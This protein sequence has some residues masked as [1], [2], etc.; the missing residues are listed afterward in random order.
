MN[1]LKSIFISGYSLI[2]MV[3]TTL[4]VIQ[5]VN[6]FSI[7][8][9]GLFLAIGLPLLLLANIMLMRNKVR[10][11]PNMPILSSIILFGA[12]ISG[13]DFFL[14]TSNNI[15]V[16]LM[17][18]VSL[19]LWL[20]YIFWYSRFDERS[21]NN[22]L[23]IGKDLPYFELENER[24]E[25]ISSTDLKGKPTIYLFYR[26]NWC[27]LCIAQ[28]KEIANQYKAI[29]ERGAQVALISPQPHKFTKGLAKKFDV[30]FKFLVDVNNKVARQLNIN[31]DAGTPFGME[32]LGYESDT[33]MPTVLITD[34]NGKIIFANLTDNYR[35]R[36]EP[37]TFLNVL[38]GKLISSYS[39]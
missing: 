2:G 1:R 30:P 21:K 27:P 19:L 22:I 9:L 3:F 10:T 39:G 35:V 31:A 11:T 15:N 29:H 14:G 4:A 6:D 36:P 17:G 7:S 32:V 20:T 33:V 25:K 23:K 28:I 38:D 18:F 5:L 12:I 16:P 26:G 24:K 37:E 13:Y 8:Y 34:K